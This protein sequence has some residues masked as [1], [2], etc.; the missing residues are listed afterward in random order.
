MHM[1]NRS[2]VSLVEVIVAMTLLGV[3]LTTLAQVSFHAARRTI[4]VAGDGYRQGILL[5]EA[6]RAATLPWA[7]LPGL[8]G[9]TT[10]AG[11]TFPHTRCTTVSALSGNTRRVTVVVTPA[12]PR[13]RRDTVIVDRTNAPTG[14]PLST[15]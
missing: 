15:F 8:A 13:V 9:C 5:Q 2:G 11:G 6:N 14:N 4:V 10:V 1:K 12:Q 3:V 7:S